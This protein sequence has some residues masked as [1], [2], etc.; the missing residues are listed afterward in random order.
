MIHAFNF[1]GTR[2]AELGQLMKHT[3][4]KYCKKLARLE[5]VN[6]DQAGYGNGGGWGPS[7][8]KVNHLRQI[9]S[10]GIGDDDWVLSVDSDVVF[11]S[12]QIF[13]WVQQVT[14]LKHYKADIIGIQQV[15]DLAKTEL[16]L[17]KN[18][19]GCSIY[20]RGWVAKKIASM[21]PDE[22]QTVR[23]EFISVKMKT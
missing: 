22:L 13:D 23:E 20:L 1:C 2:D 19:S 7:M 9:V 5:Q 21:T 3:L 11:T 6:M 18:M 4:F 16:G 10:Y 14:M 8:M 12:T 15:G 17:L